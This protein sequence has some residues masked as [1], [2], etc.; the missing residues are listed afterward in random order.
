MTTKEIT[1]RARRPDTNTSFLLPSG[2]SHRGKTY[3]NYWCDVE[4]DPTIPYPEPG[5]R[6]APTKPKRIRKPRRKLEWHEKKRNAYYLTPEWKIL[7]RQVLDR[8]GGICQY[9]GE[10]GI[11]ADHIRP[12]RK[13]GADS[14]DNL[15]CACSSCNRVAGA[16]VFKSFEAKKVWIR[17]VRNLDAT[18]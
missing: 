8:D 17:R 5:T 16:K 14:L 18:K 9:C 1:K 12:R 10:E 6:V 13:K 7:R 2:A 15:A 3:E 11:Q 4:P